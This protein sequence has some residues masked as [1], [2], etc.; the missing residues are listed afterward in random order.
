MKK[1]FPLLFVL[2]LFAACTDD[3]DP[4]DITVRLN[5]TDIPYNSDEVWEGV[6]TNNPFLVQYL[7]FSHDGEMGPW[8]LVWRGFTPARVATVEAQTDWLAHQFQIATGGGMSGKG[9]PYIVAFWDT[10]EN[11]TTPVESRSCRVQYKAALTSEVR[12]FRPMSVYVVNT[13]YTLAT[14]RDGNPYAAKFTDSDWLRLT[15]HGVHADGS[16]STTDFDLAKG[17]Q[18]VTEWT[19]MDLSP[20]GEVTTLYFT[21]SSSDTGQWG[22]NTPSYFALDCLTYRAVLP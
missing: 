10:Q 1:L 14:M 21:M 4:I 7:E 12:T 5:T 22:M 3:D 16:E 17:T 9:T 2:C 8:G 20:L 15:A 6:S 13:G 11:E 19:M 18:F